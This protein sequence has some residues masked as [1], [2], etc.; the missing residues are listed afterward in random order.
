[1]RLVLCLVVLTSFA[2]ADATT[3]QKLVR[4]NIVELGNLAD[5]DALGLADDAIVINQ[6]G[7]R[8]DLSEEAGC[9]EGAVANSFYGCNQSTIT[10]KPGSIDV[11]LDMPKRFG[12]F[13]APF[14][15][16][17]VGEDENGKEVRS[18]E[19]LR[20]MGIALHDG[21]QWKIVAQMYT[22]PVP[23]AKLAANGKPAP[24]TPK[25]TGDSKLGRTVASWFASGFKPHAGA[26]AVSLH[27]SGTSAK[28]QA[29]GAAALKLVATFD[30]LK[31]APVAIDAKL[32]AGGKVGWV[33]ADVVMPHRKSK[34]TV[35]MK[36]AIIAVPHGDGW[37]WVSLG[38]QY[39]WQP[40]AR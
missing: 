18:R 3:L 14:T 32:L 29:W 21:K 37:R 26:A 8:I 31:I 34:K 36:L 35:E 15:V 6:M 38:Y 24:A 33:I 4:Q 5:D 1:M 25:L 11:G 22:L 17:S 40:W 28:E 20:T 13:Q 10:H 2:H 39:A 19:V 7:S 23:D 30:K 27:V 16:L 12:W 9:V